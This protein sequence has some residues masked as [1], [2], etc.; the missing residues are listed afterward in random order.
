M[1]LGL[2]M[3]GMSMYAHGKPHRVWGRST[4]QNSQR[5]TNSWSHAWRAAAAEASARVGQGT[6]QAHL[7]RIVFILPWCLERKQLP[8]NQPKREDVLKKSNKMWC[9][10]YMFD[11]FDSFDLQSVLTP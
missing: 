9:K 8:E 10:A 7:P 5:V 11:I 6:L 1:C 3:E 4:W 2:C